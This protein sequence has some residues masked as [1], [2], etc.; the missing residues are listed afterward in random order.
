[1]NIYKSDRKILKAAK[2]ARIKPCAYFYADSQKLLF[3]HCNDCGIDAMRHPLPTPPLIQWS[4]FRKR[5]RK[6]DGIPDIILIHF[7]SFHYCLD[8]S[9]LRDI[10]VRERM[11]LRPFWWRG[12]LLFVVPKGFHRTPIRN[13]HNVSVHGSVSTY[14][15]VDECQ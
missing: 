5:C 9:D 1:M 14:S 10:M 7:S 6:S 12:I 13:N 15:S 2:S 8:N 3:Y 11:N 4:L